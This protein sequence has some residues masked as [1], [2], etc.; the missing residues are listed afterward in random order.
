MEEM[1]RVRVSSAEVKSFAGQRVAMRAGPGL[2]V[3]D[4]R[5]GGEELVS[6]GAPRRSIE[7]P[8]HAPDCRPGRTPGKATWIGPT[9]RVPVQLPGVKGLQPVLTLRVPEPGKLGSGW[10]E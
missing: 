8:N 4:Q 7:L 3:D 1:V 5:W 2:S 10:Q 6:R 9:A